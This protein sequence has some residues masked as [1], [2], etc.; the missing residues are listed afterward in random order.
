MH[1]AVF[2]RALLPQDL[3]LEIETLTREEAMRAS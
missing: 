1:N 3:E 2:M